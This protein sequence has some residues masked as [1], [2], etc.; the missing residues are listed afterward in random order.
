MSDQRMSNVF[1]TLNG[2]ISRYKLH[3]WREYHCQTICVDVMQDFFS[4]RTSPGGL[5]GALFVAINYK[6]TLFRRRYKKLVL[7]A[8]LCATAQQSYCRHAGVRRPSVRRPSVKLIFSEPVKQINAKFGGKVPFH[9]ISRPFFFVSQNFAI[10]IFYEF[11]S[12]TW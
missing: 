5:L 4:S 3:W 6:I 11:L 9:H 2:Y 8:L 10:F 7:L 1:F 12:L